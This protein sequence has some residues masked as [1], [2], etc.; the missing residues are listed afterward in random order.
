M[1]KLESV[2]QDAGTKVETSTNRGKENSG[3]DLGPLGNKDSKDAGLK[4]AGL[5]KSQ[6]LAGLGSDHSNSG[7]RVGSMAAL[8]AEGVGRSTPDAPSAPAT[9]PRGGRY[10]AQAAGCGAETAQAALDAFRCAADLADP[11]EPVLDKVLTCAQAGLSAYKA[12]TCEEPKKE[13]NKPKQAEPAPTKKEEE[14]TEETG[15]GMTADDASCQEGTVPPP[16]PPPTPE[17][18]DTTDEDGCENPEDDGRGRPIVSEA[19]LQAMASSAVNSLTQPVDPDTGVGGISDAPQM[20]ANYS[21]KTKLA[22]YSRPSGEDDNSG[23][24]GGTEVEVKGGFN[25]LIQFDNP[26]LGGINPQGSGDTQRGNENAGS[27]RRND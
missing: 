1:Q 27:D 13:E 19:E 10:S 18:P 4:K 17:T 14:K 26:D 7:N 16:P 2:L 11:Q 15:G 21:F 24:V 9:G 25:T 20:N 12:V 5:G 8:D 23:G 3:G 22:P 6:K